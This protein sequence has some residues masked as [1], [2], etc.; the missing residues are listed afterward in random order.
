MAKYDKN[1]AEKWLNEHHFGYY[2]NEHDKGTGAEEIPTI[3]RIFEAW[4]DEPE[5]LT[6]DPVDQDR[7]H[8][9]LYGGDREYCDECGRR[10]TMGE[11]GGYC[12]HCHPD[13]E[14]YEDEYLDDDD[15]D[16]EWELIDR[17]NVED[18]DGF[19][20]E[21]SWYQRGDEH[22]MVFGDSDLYRPEDGDYDAEFDSEER[23]REWFSSYEGFTDHNE[24]IDKDRFNCLEDECV[25]EKPL[26]EA[27]TYR[28]IPNT[29]YVYHGEWSDPEVY[30]NGKGF[31][32]WD[33]E[34]YIWGD[35]VETCEDSGEEPT[36]EGFAKYCEEN[37]E[38]LCNSFYYSNLEFMSAKEIVEE[39]EEFANDSLG[40][41]YMVTDDYVEVIFNYPEHTNGADDFI[42]DL[43]DSYLGKENLIKI[44]KT[45]NSTG[46]ELDTDDYE[47]E[48]IVK[49]TA[50]PNPLSEDI[51]MENIVMEEFEDAPYTKSEIRD[52][53]R[54]ET[55]N[56]TQVSDEIY[57]GFE[58]EYDYALVVLKKHYK[59][60]EG[61]EI[62][63]R[64]VIKFSDP[65]KR[66]KE[67][68]TNTHRNGTLTEGYVRSNGIAFSRIDDECPELAGDSWCAEVSYFHQY[69]AGITGSTSSST[70]Y[71]GSGA[72]FK[73]K[74]DLANA[75]K[76]LG[77]KKMSKQ[78]RMTDDG[79][80]GT[81]KVDIFY[82][83]V[84]GAKRIFNHS[85]PNW[86]VL[87]A[88]NSDDNLSEGWAHFEFTSGSNPYIAKTEEDKKRLCN[89]WGK[90]CEFKGNINGNDYYVIN[91]KPVETPFVD[92][93]IDESLNEG[94]EEAYH[95]DVRQL[96]VGT[97]VKITGTGWDGEDFTIEAFV[98]G[99]DRDSD[100]VRI[101]RDESSR[102][103]ADS[104]HY[105]EVN[106]DDI[107]DVY[108]EESVFNSELNENKE[109]AL[110]DYKTRQATGS[111]DR[112]DD[113]YLLNQDEDDY[114]YTAYD[115]YDN[116]ME[117]FRTEKDAMDYVDAQEDFDRVAKVTRQEG[118]REIVI[119]R[120]DDGESEQYDESIKSPDAV[121]NALTKFRREAHPT[122]DLDTIKRNAIKVAKRDGYNQLIVKDDDGSYSIVREYPDST[123]N[124]EVVGKVTISYKDGVAQTDYKELKESIL[125]ND[126]YVTPSEGAVEQFLDKYGFGD[127]RYPK[128]V[129]TDNASKGKEIVV[130]FTDGISASDFR[131]IEKHV[132]EFFGKCPVEVTLGKEHKDGGDLW[133]TIVFDFGKCRIDEAKQLNEGPGAGYTLE[134]EIKVAGIET[135]K[136]VKFDVCNDFG[137]R[138][139]YD[140]TFDC[141]GVGTIEDFKFDSY[142][143]GDTIDS[144][145]IDISAVRVNLWKEGGFENIEEFVKSNLEDI[146]N[147]I[148]GARVESSYVYGGGYIHSKFDGTICNIDEILNT[149]YSDEF[150]EV[151]TELFAMDATIRDTDIIE[152]VDKAVTGDNYYDR[153]EVM[154]DGDCIEDF[155]NESEAIEYAKKDPDA[156]E[157]VK[158]SYH[159]LFNG[160]IDIEESETVWE[161]EDDDFDESFKSIPGGKAI[162]ESLVKTTLENY[163]NASSKVIARKT[164]DKS[165]EKHNITFEKWATL[166]EKVNK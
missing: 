35:Y 142:M 105:E 82:T 73:N 146:K 67:S 99:G 159:E 108:Y 104:R 21:Y 118:K 53:L 58:S 87:T 24:G 69:A 81:K 41:I 78:G 102:F 60:V 3:N 26:N 12:S 153:Y 125:T 43:E 157:V 30:I 144:A 122:S 84:E 158:T 48:V 2:N 57:Y 31:S 97:R 138:N 154:V 150:G 86:V 140:V 33:V 66:L 79:R 139:S 49:V 50:T 45:D 141:V 88:D 124:R 130:S 15:T 127:D 128:N 75:L 162:M 119:Y 80:V 103:D 129:Y 135:L 32:E 10:L 39:V 134:G 1:N 110:Y 121:N 11:W 46:D 13:Y 36:D 98:L 132:G 77:I 151:C 59:N 149:S 38:D 47:P 5:W 100:M 147:C 85:R 65:N 19:I 152:Y 62:G 161:R 6:A 120:E 76:A 165:F 74:N 107:T 71:V 156:D 126:G 89:K 95:Y 34:D 117:S 20:T 56:W 68:T 91:D 55:N 72:G 7:E 42:H 14:D 109:D 83:K 18:S 8:A 51:V 164:F 160:D 96:P 115:R 70:L 52:E 54:R 145:N 166:V 106:A 92:D 37:G 94:W 40:M 123:D 4:D 143:Y 131:V 116:P 101:T 44:E 9:N 133:A 111:W 113:D 27:K 93:S 29:I 17:K 22:V 148:V 114:I 112:D 137:Y 61:E 16:S 23:A 63:N 64:Y 136:P 28:G 90:D 163:P 155:D 25:E